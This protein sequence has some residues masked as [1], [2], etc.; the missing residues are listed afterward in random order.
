MKRKT[1]QQV[2]GLRRHIGAGTLHRSTRR[3]LLVAA[4][5]AFGLPSAAFSQTTPKYA[6]IGVLGAGSPAGWAKMVDALRAGL[7]ALGYVEDKNLVIEYRWA[8]GNYDNLPKLVGELIAAKVDVIVT[9]A[10]PGA[11]AAMQ[12]T[13]SVPIVVASIGDAV[14][15]GIVTNLAHPGGNL[16]GLSFF[17]T[18]IAAKR[19][20]LLTEL[21]PRT[22]AINLLYQQY[23]SIVLA[24]IDAAARAKKVTI[25]RIFTN[26]PGEIQ[27]A[28]ANIAQKRSGPILVFETPI[29]IAN[30]KFI[31]ENLVKYKIPAIGFKEIAE[32]GGLMSYG[33]D[34][35][36][37]WR[38][39][40]TY[41]D[42]ILKGANP[43]SIPIEQATKF[44]L[45]INMKAAKSL[46]IK[47]P[48][49]LLLRADKVIE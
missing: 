29:L 3:A 41:V 4:V 38:R 28:I 44:E 26:T 36:D 49:S 6:R 13:S 40:A 27:T 7:N 11:R 39:A 19:I 46:G 12:A 48:Q 32:A 25:H 8:E 35:A 1:V 42:K 45:V 16:T 18:E 9:H 15:A 43:G 10:T 24:R 14:S 5:A 20:E 37:M 22:S 23:M 33:A 17:S 34:L 2:A 21:L 31:G 47:M 30:A